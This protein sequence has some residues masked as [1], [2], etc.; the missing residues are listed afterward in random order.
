MVTTD[1]IS[2]YVDGELVPT[3]QITRTLTKESDITGTVNGTSK[4]IGHQY[5]L[6]LSDLEQA[7]KTIDYNREYSDWSGNYSIKIAEGAVQDTNTPEPNKNEETTIEGDM[8]D[9]IKPNATYKYTESDIDYD[10]K[11]FISSS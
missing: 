7:R 8:V 3:D 2:V 10:G 6:V 4:V 1:E 9:F 5:K 11:T